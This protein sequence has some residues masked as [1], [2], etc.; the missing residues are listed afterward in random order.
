M[1]GRYT[2]SADPAALVD[3]FDAELQVSEAILPRYNIAPTQE[4][5]IVFVDGAQRVMTT[6]TWGLIPRWSKDRSA[7]ARLINARSETVAEK[8]S[9]RDAIRRRRCVVPTTGY[10]EWYRPASGAKQPF[11]IHCGELM[12]MAGVYEYWT[13]P[14]TG[15]IVR[16]AAILTQN[17]T[18]SLA[19]IHDRMPVFVEFDHLAK[20]LDP[21]LT[22]PGEALALTTSLALDSVPVSTAVNNAR[23]EG[24]ELIVPIQAE[25]EGVLF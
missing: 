10:Y 20:W 2:L 22:D 16:S 23:H 5:L 6:A 4:I 8:P 9:F 18:P 19:S 15:E 1:C 11:H 7:A 24:P 12:A 3:A 14:D 17:A 25:I 21:Q 13:D